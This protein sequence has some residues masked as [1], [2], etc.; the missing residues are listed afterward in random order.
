MEI[1]I[2]LSLWCEWK[3]VFFVLVSIPLIIV[4]N[5]L[6]IS[7]PF[8]CWFAP[9]FGINR[10]KSGQKKG[11]EAL[12]WCKIWHLLAIWSR[13][14]GTIGS[15]Q[16][17][18]KRYKETLKFNKLQSRRHHVIKG[19]RFKSK[20]GKMRVDSASWYKAIHMGSENVGLLFD[21]NIHVL[22]ELLLNLPN[23]DQGLFKKKQT[24][25]HEDV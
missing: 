21:Q 12:V 20:H 22:S 18:G 1:N 15:C 23:L 4:I 11:R 3:D 24:I 25:Q 8:L 10:Y 17:P 5:L 7:K 2:Q 16:N 19:K 6:D 9:C 13:T 14:V